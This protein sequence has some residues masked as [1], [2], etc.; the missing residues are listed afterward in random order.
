MKAKINDFP[1]LISEEDIPDEV[2]CEE[3]AERKRQILQ[4][5]RDFK[6]TLGR[7]VVDANPSIFDKVH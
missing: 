4:F 3:A 7:A 5:G 1:I 2:T 6:Q